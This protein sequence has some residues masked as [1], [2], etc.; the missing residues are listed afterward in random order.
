MKNFNLESATKRY[1]RIMNEICCEHLT[2]GT[3]YSENTDGW[4]IRDMV[5]EVESLEKEVRRL[6][7]ARRV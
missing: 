1:N 6:K 2:I 3:S 5:D 4:N 7:Y